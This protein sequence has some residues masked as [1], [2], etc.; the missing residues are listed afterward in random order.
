MVFPGFYSCLSFPCPLPQ[1]KLSIF[2]FFF[3]KKYSHSLHSSSCKWPTATLHFVF[4]F[5]GHPIGWTPIFKTF[6]HIFRTL[7]IWGKPNE[8][9]CQVHTSSIH[10]CVFVGAGSLW[11]EKWPSFLE[12][13][14]SIFS[15][16]ERI[17]IGQGALWKFWFWVFFCFCCMPLQ[18]LLELYWVKQTVKS[19]KKGLLTS[20]YTTYIFFKFE[21]H[22]MM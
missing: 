21:T 7:K 20:F 6:W 11:P 15:Q 16:S 9:K 2:T 12:N 13:L 19:H 14:A 4:L 3:L 5:W 10:G 1:G 22:V 17:E 18:W 8:K